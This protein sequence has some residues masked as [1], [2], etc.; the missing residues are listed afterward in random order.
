MYFIIIIFVAA[1]LAN[2]V[3]THFRS[4]RTLNLSNIN[5]YILVI[6]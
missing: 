3:Q 4:I 6:K 5:H 1:F 2:R